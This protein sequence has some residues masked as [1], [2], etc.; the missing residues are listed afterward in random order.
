MFLEPLLCNGLH[1][2]FIA[3][4]ITVEPSDDTWSSKTCFMFT[5]L[6]MPV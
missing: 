4:P 2:C 5:V 3:E 1:V 6:I